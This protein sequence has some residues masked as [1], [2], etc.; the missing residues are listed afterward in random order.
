MSFYALSGL[1]NGITSTVLGI[2]IFLKV[3]RR[4]DNPLYISYV[5]FCLSVSVWSYFYFAWMITGIPQKAL[6]YSRCLMMG[7]MYIPIF[8]LHHLLYLLGNFNEKK[9]IIFFGYLFTFVFLLFGFS[10]YYVES[11]SLKFC[12]E[13]WPNPGI[14]YHMFLILWFY[15]VA[16]GVYILLR[17]FKN[18]T[19][20]KRNQIKYVLFATVCGWLG[21]ATNFPLWYNIKIFPIGNI[22]VS[23]Y[24]IIT[25]YAIIK[26]HLMDIR[27]ALTR[28]GV[29][30]C[31]YFIALGLPLFLGYKYGMWKTAAYSSII[32][33]FMGSFVYGYFKRRAENALLKEQIRYQVTLKDFS[34]KLIF[35]RDENELSE[36]LVSR[37]M[38]IVN[39]KFCAMYI[40]DRDKLYL[41]NIKCNGDIS[42]PEKISFNDKFIRAFKNINIPI[43]GEDL[44]EFKDL[45]IGMV[46]PLFSKQ[47]FYGFIVLGQK[48]NNIMFTD[49]DIDVFS[50]VS[51][52]VSLALSEIYYFNEYKKA[53]EEKFK[54]LIEKEKLESAFQISEA[55][56]HELG[57]IINIISMSLGDITFTENYNPGKEEIEHAAGSILANVKRAQYVFDVINLYNEHSVSE[58][59]KV[60]LSEILSSII[61]GYENECKA[62][63]IDIRNKIKKNIFFEINRNFEFAFK[64][65]LEGAIGAIRYTLPENKIIE[66]GLEET[67]GNIHLRISDTGGNAAENKFYKGVGIVRAKDGGICYFLA[68][69]IMFDHNG[70]FKVK[71][72]YDAKGTEF[73]IEFDVTK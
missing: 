1:I 68:R 34:S 18:T 62:C 53:I 59:K 55:Y 25:A 47:E 69:R 70:T 9:A 16:Y 50:I 30:L 7:A 29:F 66:V 67:A 44:P 38:E 8:Y 42:L 49:T 3:R 65:L 4:G 27:V 22:L 73:V 39:L 51:N 31:V 6:L 72:C 17:S 33:S 46:A 5:F 20:A 36:K 64:Y 54:I 57:N 71:P 35:I 14:A 58:F 2:F 23:V 24:V 32:L 13:F 12:F 43:L 11:V 52:Q 61:R 63:G 28:T 41:K 26:H 40:F 48:T 37:I 56:R 21:G 15:F 10:P 45:E 19:G 60:D